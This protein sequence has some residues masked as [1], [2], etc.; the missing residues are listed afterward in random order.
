MAIGHDPRTAEDAHGDEGYVRRDGNA[1]RTGLDIF[2]I[3][4]TAHRGLREDTNN[5]TRLEIADRVTEGLRTLLAIDRDVAHSTHQWSRDPV[6]EDRVLRHEAHQSLAPTM[7]GEATEGE[8][9]KARVVHGQQRPTL[10]WDVLLAHEVKVHAQ[11]GEEGL[12]QSHD[13]SIRRISSKCRFSHD[14]DRSGWQAVS[15]TGHPDSPADPPRDPLAPHNPPTNEEWSYTH[16]QELA[17]QRHQSVELEEFLLALGRS[18]LAAGYPVDDVTT[19]LNAVARA[20]DRADFG[21]FV[22]PNA[23]MIDDPFIGRAR[24]VPEGNETLRLD[25]AAEVHDIARQARHG[26]IDLAE[27]T[28]ELDNLTHKAPRFPPWLS[29]VGYGI[30]SAG[31]A[32]VFR[33]SMWGVVMAAICGLFVGLLLAYTRTRPNLA[34]LVPP[35][36]ATVCSFAVFSFASTIDQDVQPLRVVAAPLIALIP[37]AALT[38]ATLELASGHVIS[39][40]SRLVASIV[41]ILILTFG[42]L[43]GGLLA[44]VSPDNFSD[45]TDQRLPMWVAWV[46]AGVYALGQAIA[47]NEPRGA[48]VPVVILLLIAFSVQQLVTWVLDAVL[49]AGIAAAVALFLAIVLQDRGRRQMPAFVLFSPVFWLLVPGSLGLV[50]LTEAVSGSPDDT[51]PKSEDDVTGTAGADPLQTQLPSFTDLNLSSEASIALIFGASIIA[52]TIGMQIAS[53]AGRLVR[54]LPDLPDLPDVKMPGIGR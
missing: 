46:G 3:H 44:R 35:V 1:H 6:L 5:F 52:I 34:P 45:L 25:Q 28:R 31:F 43:V 42:I 23:V 27:G 26:E 36:A 21:I 8:V 4:R 12:G 39:G 53:I 2:D 13:R 33:V 30:A 10:E 47:F 37:G 24:V 16:D 49:A 51:L 38:R 20:Y 40:A 32:L 15:V 48:L 22:L 18:Q 7:R 50:A 9:Q 54:K 17:A 11:A 19:N 29:I 41:Q 14:H